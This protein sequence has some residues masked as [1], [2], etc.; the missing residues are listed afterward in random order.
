MS[1]EDYAYLCALPHVLHVPDAH[2]FV[3]HAGLMSH[4]PLL[5]T[6]HRKQPLA[7]VPTLNKE[8]NDADG[9]DDHSSGEHDDIDR[10]LDHNEG[11][12][13]L[14]S[15]RFVQ[16]RRI[17]NWVKPNRDPWLVMNMRTVLKDGEVTKYVFHTRLLYYNYILT[18]P[19]LL[20]T[21][22]QGT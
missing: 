1:A 13:F 16:E 15:L 21:H 2:A 10:G 5:K 22:S 19:F 9:G 8:G 20:P 14:K 7:H 4:D 6:R 11:G 3:V 18:I 12:L 17:L